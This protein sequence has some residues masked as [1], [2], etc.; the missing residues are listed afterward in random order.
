MESP[1][2]RGIG[3]AAIP[4]ILPFIVAFVIALIFVVT[5]N[6]DLGFVNGKTNFFRNQTK[7]TF[8]S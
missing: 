3:M 6:L 5:F 4:K 8:L 2:T 7:I 1:N